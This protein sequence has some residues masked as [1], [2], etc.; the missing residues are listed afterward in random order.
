MARS[1]QEQLDACD[2]NIQRIEEG[3]QAYTIRGRQKQEALL[4]T[5]YAERQRLTQQLSDENNGG[6]MVSLAYPTRVT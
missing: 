1:T 6:N 3:A 4:A 2:A 5:L